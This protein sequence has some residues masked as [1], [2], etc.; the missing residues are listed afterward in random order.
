M[1]LHSARSYEDGYGW[2][3]RVDPGLT[4]VSHCRFSVAADRICVASPTPAHSTNTIRPHPSADLISRLTRRVSDV[5]RSGSTRAYLLLNI[6]LLPIAL[7]L[8]VEQPCVRT[9][10]GQ[11]FLMGTHFGDLPMFEY[12]NPVS[13]PY[14][15]EA[16][17]NQH[18]N[19]SG[20]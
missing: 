1:V 11:Q 12:Y 7:C 16:M 14:R 3:N 19:P 13:H 15:R 20:S 10:T 5:A 17:A 9:I 4:G 2:R 18:R 6:M 8:H